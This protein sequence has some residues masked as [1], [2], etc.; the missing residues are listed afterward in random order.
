MGSLEQKKTATI[1]PGGE[2]PRL[3]TSLS[4]PQDGTELLEPPTPLR[5]GE[6]GLLVPW[7]EEGTKLLE[8][9]EKQGGHQPC[10]VV[11]KP[12]L[13]APPRKG[14]GGDTA[15]RLLRSV[16]AWEGAGSA[17][18]GFPV[19]GVLVAPVGPQR[20]GQGGQVGGGAREGAA[21]AGLGGALKPEPRAVSPARICRAA[22]PAWPHQQPVA[23]AA[24][25]VLLPADGAV[26]LTCGERDRGGR[27][28]SLGRSRPRWTPC[29]APMC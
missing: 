23:G 13:P 20:R 1:A 10:V 3:G 16:S 2:S 26:V 6:R 8:F 4:T 25:E 22:N 15:P 29:R 12:S 11:Q 27:G 9:W 5:C 24:L 7:V 19:L 14:V 28:G 21:P 17:G 18:P